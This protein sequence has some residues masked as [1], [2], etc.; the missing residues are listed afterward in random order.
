MK[1]LDIMFYNYAVYLHPTTSQFSDPSMLLCDINTP[2]K[3][4]VQYVAQCVV[5]FVQLKFFRKLIIDLLVSQTL[6]L[7]YG[8]C[9]MD[10]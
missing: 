4:M 2:N 9:T 6:I 1:Y 3:T 8:Q 7:P 10:R 5:C